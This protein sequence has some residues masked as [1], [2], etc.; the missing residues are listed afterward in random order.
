MGAG[1]AFLRIQNLFEILP[2]GW[3]ENLFF[4]KT[5]SS[6]WTLTLDFD[7]GFVKN[8]HVCEETKVLATFNSVVVL[9]SN[10]CLLGL[11]Y[12]HPDSLR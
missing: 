11:T 10:I 1:D 6:A 9:Y 5:Q 4:I 8:S 7:L 12:I 3:L 2:T